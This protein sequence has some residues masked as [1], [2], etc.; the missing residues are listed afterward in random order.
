MSSAV[1]IV[2]IDYGPA[3]SPA[4][5][6]ARHVTEQ[7]RALLGL[8][9]PWRWRV[10][11]REGQTAPDGSFPTLE[12]VVVPGRSTWR[13]ATFGL[14]AISH[15]VSL[16]FCTAYF[17]PLDGPP[18]IANFFDS[19]VYEHLETWMASGRLLNGLLIRTLS[20]FAIHRSDRLFVNSHYCAYYLRRKFPRAEHKF[21]VTPPGIVSPRLS[22]SHG[23]PAWAS[24]LTTPFF[25][26]VGVFS[27][28]KNQRRLIEAFAHVQK[29]SCQPVS[30]VLI[31]PCDR[32]FALKKIH[33]AQRSLPHPERLLLAG[34][35]SEAD[36]AWAYAN[37][38]AYL[39]PSIAEGFGLP[40]LEAMSLDLPVACSN[41]TSLPETA[42][43]CALLFD[44]HD[45]HSMAEAML[46]L[47]NEPAVR[48]DLRKRGQ[49]RWQAFTWQR[50]ARQIADVIEAILTQR[51]HLN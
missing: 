44:P 37:A 23:K 17:V 47:L 49:A 11:L 25:L 22:Q 50:N 15:G 43:G 46:R 13:R 8:P 21:L 7:A 6:T 32:R 35:V 1:P 20:S 31:G 40:I 5:G 14:R 19:N 28:N 18:V 36:L 10:A 24:E 26:Y 45:P 41:T 9:V 42:G 2:L 27:E 51:K 12:T 3:L 33:P 29:R 48:D 16:V 30:L 4:P 39:Q 34:R 38:M